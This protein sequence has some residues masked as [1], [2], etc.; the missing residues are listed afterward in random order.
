MHSVI[1]GLRRLWSTAD[2]QAI[3]LCWRL[4]KPLTTECLLL[5]NVCGLN[6]GLYKYLWMDAWLWQ[7]CE[8]SLLNVEKV[9]NII[10]TIVNIFMQLIDWFRLIDWLIDGWMDRLI[11]ATGMAVG[12]WERTAGRNIVR[13]EMLP[14]EQ[15]TIA[16]E[17]GSDQGRTWQ[18]NMTGIVCFIAFFHRAFDIRGNFLP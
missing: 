11:M 8:S 2:I 3:C 15:R 17:H 16:A 5:C 10:E 18:G 14:G 12:W 4:Q 7:I 6:I 1:W 9:S 13:C